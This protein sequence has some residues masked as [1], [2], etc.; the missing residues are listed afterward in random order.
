MNNDQDVVNQA[1][2]TLY[3][4]IARKQMYPDE[5]TPESKAL[6]V[7]SKAAG[8]TGSNIKTATQIDDRHNQAEKIAHGD[9]LDMLAAIMP[10]LLKRREG[11]RMYMDRP[12]EGALQYLEA[13]NKKISEILQLF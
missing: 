7:L 13:I 11:A 6:N 8:V 9:D 10:Y 4:F 1:W 3:E 2:H 12:S 5:P